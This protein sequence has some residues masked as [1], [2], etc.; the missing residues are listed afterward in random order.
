MTAVAVK[1][2]INFLNFSAIEATGEAFALAAQYGVK[3][4]DF[5]EFITSTLFGS[6]PYK[7]YGKLIERNSYVPANFV[8]PLGLKD[9]KL[10]L[11]AA[12]KVNLAMPLADVVRDHFVQAMAQGYRDEDIAV[13]AHAI[14]NTLTRRN[15]ESSGATSNWS[16]DGK[17]EQGAGGREP[18]ADRGSGGKPVSQPR[19]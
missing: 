5:Y 9:V 6:L 4:S 19:L 7:A 8:V 15:A 14:T 11:D 17:I 13:L 12:E 18:S 3:P 10:A 2:A 16:F 1:L